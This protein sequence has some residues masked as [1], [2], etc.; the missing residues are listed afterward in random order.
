MNDDELKARLRR[1]RV[2][3]P[4]DA[5]ISEALKRASA[6]LREEVIL[7]IK[8]PGSTRPLWTWR[9]WLWPSPIAWA[10]MAVVWITALCRESV[11][12]PMTPQS[13]P[14]VVAHA[15]NRGDLSAVARYAEYQAERRQL[16]KLFR[17]E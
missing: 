17:P 8:T 16:E 1:L 7:P 4:S 12:R 5:A 3:S 6:A 2:P 9:D 15:P 13:G 11:T 10:A 14:A